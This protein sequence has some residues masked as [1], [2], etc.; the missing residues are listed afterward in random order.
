VYARQH[1]NVARR[2]VRLRGERSESVRDRWWQ[3]VDAEQVGDRD[4]ER[5]GE[6]Q[7]FLL[8]RRTCPAFNQS[9]LSLYREASPDAILAWLDRGARH[10]RGRPLQPAYVSGGLL[11]VPVGDAAV[12][13]AHRFALAQTIQPFVR[14]NPDLPRSLHALRTGVNTYPPGIYTG[15][16]QFLDLIDEIRSSERSMELGHRGTSADAYYAIPLVAFVA[17]DTFRRYFEGRR[18]QDPDGDL[19]FRDVI[20][21]Y[22]RALYPLDTV[23]PIGGR[24]E[25]FPFLYATSYDLKG[26]RDKAFT[27]G[28]LL[29]SNEMNVLNMIL[30]EE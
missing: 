30:A 7:Q 3:C 20:Y 24:Y 8:G 10:L 13:T 17:K 22:L 4:P 12:E 2:Q 6:G 25:E 26:M 27:R 5:G 28:H 11:V 15:A 9:D 14:D 16:R 23:L 19:P 29:M 1:L 21:R 18:D